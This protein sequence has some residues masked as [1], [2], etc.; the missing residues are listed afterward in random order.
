MTVRTRPTDMEQLLKQFQ[1]LAKAKDLD[2]IESLWIEQLP[3]LPTKPVFYKAWLKIMKSAKAMDRAEMLLGMQLDELIKQNKWKA[4]M[5]VLLATIPS[6]QRSDILRPQLITAMR[7]FYEDLGDY[8]DVFL[9]LSKLEQDESLVNGFKSFRDWV[10][11]TPGQVYQHYDWGEGVIQELDLDSRKVR[12]A[13]PSE[14]NK[15]MTVEGVRKFLR[16]VEPGSFLA[17]RTKSPDEL[18][19][20]SDRDP[21]EVVRLAL[22]SQEDRTLRQSDL[23]DLMINGVLSPKQ[24]NAWWGRARDVLR[25]DPYIDIDTTGGA[26]ATIR[27]RKRA[28]TFGDE[29][30][31]TFLKNEGTVADR[32]ELIRR[33]ARHREDQSVTEELIAQL[34]EHV[35]M[36]FEA[37]EAEHVASRLERIYLLED[38]E[39]AVGKLPL[40]TPDPAPLIGNIHDYNLLFEMEH[41]D[42]AARALTAL[43]K[44]DREEGFQSAIN[45]LPNAPLRL[46]QA[47]WNSLD[48][49]HQVDHAMGALQV[50]FDHPIRNVD[51]YLWALKSTLDGSWPHMEEYFPAS[52]MVPELLEE[53]GSWHQVSGDELTSKDQTSA[54]KTLLSRCRTMLQADKFDLVA[55]AVEEIPR[56]TALRVRRLV[57]N[58]DALSDSFKSQAERVILLTRRDLEEEGKD[59]EAELHYCTAR[60]YAKATTELRELVSVKIP[61]NTRE[62]EAAR[63]EGDLR[64]NAGYQYAKEEQKL[65]MQ[66]QASLTE[67]LHRSRIVR[68]A[69]VDASKIGFGTQFTAFNDKLGEEETYTVL[70]RWEADPERHILSVHAPMAQQFLGCREQSEITIRH[71][72]GTSTP[73]RVL[74]IRNALAEGNWDQDVAPG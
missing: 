28:Y 42:Y 58:H 70:G 38:L 30:R 23:K 16:F 50:L 54:A 72:D 3:L 60:A 68:A 29:V 13:F 20:L 37:M 61:E 62:I 47:I 8:F 34:S 18:R 44:R 5:R 51:T 41:V 26:R 45:L 7:G 64:E 9:R 53:M 2:A 40:Q 1:E 49:E 19:E 57:Q 15:E 35:L 11:L 73:Y 24:W 43:L 25:V 33:I 32:A 10:R 59:P 39:Q 36:E 65:L 69:E 21:A 14:P 31:D 12:L 66:K 46:A 27:L 17:R 56:E 48:K 67:L 74:E 52:A 55:K 4:A 71:P 63:A 6:F 22:S